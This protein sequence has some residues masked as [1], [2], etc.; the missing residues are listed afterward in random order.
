[1]RCGLN[2]IFIGVL[3]LGCAQGAVKDEFRSL[4]ESPG[5][6]SGS[7][8]MLALCGWP[9]I[10]KLR[11]VSIDVA[12]SPESS[13]KHGSGIADISAKGDMFAC[14]ARIEFMYQHTYVG[15]HGYSGGTEIQ[16]RGFKKMNAVDPA[17]SDPPTARPIRMGETIKGVLDIKSGRLPDGSFADYY[18][19]DLDRANPLVRFNLTAERGLNPKGYVYQER[20]L[21][22]EFGSR[23]SGTRPYDNVCP[24]EK[25]RAVILISARKQTGSYTIRLDEPDDSVRSMLRLPERYRKKV[26]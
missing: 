25:G 16:L 17:I 14:R 3:L 9:T 19:T 4:M 23:W 12:L 22:D 10:V 8:L 26:P 18:Y 20:K 15:G 6:A 21:I 2:V 5:T 1:M 11:P 24:L 13:R 7:D